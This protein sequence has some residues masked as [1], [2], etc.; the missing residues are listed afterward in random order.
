MTIASIAYQG[1]P[2]SFSYLAATKYFGLEQRWLG[3]SHF[4]DIFKLIDDKTAN[5]GIVPVENS[6]AGSVYEN[7]DLLGKYNLAVVGEFYLKVTHHLLCLPQSGSI[8]VT[9]QI[10]QITQVV[11]HPKA[12]EQCTK[13]FEHH[14]WIEQVAFS[15]TARAAQHVAASD[16]HQ[17]AAIASQAAADLYNL[18]IIKSNL[19]DDPHN[20]TRFLVIAKDSLNQEMANKCSI[21]FTVSHRPGSLFCALEVLAKNSL[22]LTKL[23]SRPIPEK[24]FEY[25]FYVDFE[26]TPGVQSLIEAILAEFRKHT[27]A[28]KVLG[29]Y[30][31]ATR[32]D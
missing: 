21:I 11:S 4:R 2:G 25:V 24:P 1:I 7:Y 14:P 17:V 12:L 18:K 32:E 22:N 8:P 10:K 26:F 6:L 29:Y 23:E 16:C 30:R 27:N 20:Y 5:Y 31:A 3:T 13:F 19:E 9:T 28:F 15:D